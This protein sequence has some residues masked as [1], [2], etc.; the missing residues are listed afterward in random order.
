MRK[1]R[2]DPGVSE[3]FSATDETQIK[4][5]YRK[6]TIYKEGREAR[7]RRERFNH[8]WIQTAMDA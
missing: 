7:M 1:S 5:G 6:G 3:G 2:S 8:G 4:H